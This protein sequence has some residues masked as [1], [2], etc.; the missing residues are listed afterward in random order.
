MQSKSS[1]K[2][3]FVIMPFGSNKEYR[4]GSTEANIVY[5]KIILPGIRGDMGDDV[6][7][8][9][10]VDKNETGSVTSS[11]IQQIADADICIVDLTGRNPN[12]FLELG[13]RFALKRKTTV[14]MH[15]D[16]SDLPFDVKSYRCI[17]YN[18]LEQSKFSEKLSSVIRSSL[19]ADSRSDSLVFDSV[20]HLREYVSVGGDF[21]AIMTWSDYFSRVDVISEKLTSAHIAGRYTPSAIIGISN[22]G[23]MFAD[24]LGQRAVFSG[25]VVTLWARRHSGANFSHPANKGLISGLFGA[26]KNSSKMEKHNILLVD[27]IIASGG[28]MSRPKSL[29]TQICQKVTSILGF[30]PC[31]LETRDI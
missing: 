15:Q 2:K 12:V 21:D 9:R 7:V 16:V 17:E 14:L 3:C 22:G 10:E 25:P 23:G 6:Q 13:I 5:E 26:S 1:V 18:A 30:C 4:L 31:V 29:Y 28:H 20:R 19:D 24:L 27:D 11:I 8:H